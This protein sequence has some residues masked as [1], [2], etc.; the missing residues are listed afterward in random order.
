MVRNY[1]N[2]RTRGGG[3]R[4]SWAPTVYTADL[5]HSHFHD[6]DLCILLH[7]AEDDMTHEVVKKA[8]LKAAK[9]RVKALGMKHD[10]QVSSSRAVCCDHCTHFVGVQSIREYKRNFHNHDPSWHDKH[11]PDFSPEVCCAAWYSVGYDS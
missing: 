10:M 1:L 11:H 4:S 2:A 9:A 8:I 3:D 5:K 6:Q 7:A